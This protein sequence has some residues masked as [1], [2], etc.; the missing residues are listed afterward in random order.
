MM[1]EEGGRNDITLVDMRC[2]ACFHIE[3]DNSQT[4]KLAH[5]NAEMFI[6]S[7][8]LTLGQ[9]PVDHA[10]LLSLLQLGTSLLQSRNFQVLLEARMVGC[11]T[12]LVDFLDAALRLGNFGSV[13]SPN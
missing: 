5:V 8:Q 1:V 12:V 3:L 6:H 4:A 13:G 10:G 7:S 9:L 11:G 2:L